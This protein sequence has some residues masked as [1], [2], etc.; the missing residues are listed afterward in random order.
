MTNIVDPKLPLANS[1]PNVN[2]NSVL[3]DVKLNITLDDVKSGLNWLH[4]GQKEKWLADH[5]ANGMAAALDSLEI[6][7][8]MFEKFKYGAELY[9][10]LKNGSVSIETLEHFIATLLGNILAKKATLKLGIGRTGSEQDA[11]R[12]RRY[13]YIIDGLTAALNWI[14]WRS[15]NTSST[16]APKMSPNVIIKSA[17]IA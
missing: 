3:R 14:R 4:S 1:R 13:G 7:D 6:Y 5:V 9:S 12:L 10:Q 11:A 2:F 17:S 15:P 16:T 8:Y